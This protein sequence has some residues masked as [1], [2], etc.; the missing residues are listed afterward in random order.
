M[1]VPELAMGLVQAMVSVARSCR[2]LPGP[3][4]LLRWRRL[5]LL[6]VPPCLSG[7]GCHCL[8]AALRLTSLVV[9]PMGR[10]VGVRCQRVPAQ[11]PGMALAMRSQRVLPCFMVHPSQRRWWLLLVPPRL[12]G[13]R[14][15]R[16]AVALRPT[17][18]AKRTTR[19]MGTKRRT[20]CGTLAKAC[21]RNAVWAPRV[22]SLSVSLRMS[23]QGCRRYRVALA[24]KWGRLWTS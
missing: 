19:G 23:R 15:H 22:P 16:M 20:F 5:L 3:V 17:F 18:L 11:V 9:K 24:R 7:D 6:L 1:W 12:S 2:P 10:A 14:C 21:L 4:L 13:D 8:P